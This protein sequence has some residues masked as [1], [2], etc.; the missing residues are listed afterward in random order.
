MTKTQ[1]LKRYIVVMGLVGALALPCFG[2][3][4]KVGTT[5]GQFLKIGLGA[6]SIGMG[7][8]VVASVNDVSALYWNPAAIADFQKR[9]ALASYTDWFLETKIAYTGV[10]LPMGAIGTFGFSFNSLSMDMMDVRTVELPEGTGEQ[11][12][13][14]DLAIGI[15]YAKKLTNFFNVGF[16]AKYIRESIWHCDATSL[17]FDFGSLYRTDNN[18]LVIG[19]SVSNFGGEMQFLGRDLRVYYD[20]SISETGDNETIPAYYETDEWDLPLTFRIGLAVNLPEFPIGDMVAEIDAIHPNDNNEQVNLGVEWN[21]SK[22]L[23]LRT[24][25]QALF[26][27]NAE[28]GLTAGVGLRCKMLNSFLNVNYAYADYGRLAAVQQF[29]MEI[30]F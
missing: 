11:F 15:S 16:N 13:A 24:G 4:T 8:A 28:Q 6:R 12:S 26:Q 1:Y 10:V 9:K 14:G 27:Q 22:I 17:A 20:Q 29:E 21:L 2:K 30:E 25:Y 19:A 23:F 18:R 7:G 3:I 5:M